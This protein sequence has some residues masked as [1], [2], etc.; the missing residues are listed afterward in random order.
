MM[1]SVLARCFAVVAI[2][3]AAGC[4]GTAP[5]ATE[6]PPPPVHAQEVALAP[7]TPQSTATAEILANRQSN[8]RSET[9]GAVVDVRIEVGDRVEAGQVLLRLDV[10]RSASAAQ[11]ANAAVAQSDARLD[12]AQRELD[13]TKKLVRTGGLPEQRLDDAEDAVRL[14]LAA[15]DAARAEARLARRGVTDAE[16]RAPFEGTI[17]ERVVELGEYV[18]PGSPLLTLADTSLLKARVLLDPRE[19][20]DVSVGSPVS[21]SVYARPGEA[22]AGEVVRVGEVIDPRTRRLPVEIELADHGGRLR[23]GL[24]AKFTVQTGDATMA[25]RVPLEGVFERFGSQHVYVVVDGI[26]HRRA[27]TLGQIRDGRAEVIEGIEPG[28]LVVTKGVTRVV[29]ASKVMVVPPEEAAAA[30]PSDSP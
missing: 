25:L 24:V 13:R 3:A 29:D 28:D 14:A 11:A 27:V 2:S 4:T 19:A 18:A 10:G 21:I 15:R 1:R 30:A 17:V 6:A 20:L 16:V 9:A 23:P 5:A 12:Q 7:V 8:M 22:Y 26:A